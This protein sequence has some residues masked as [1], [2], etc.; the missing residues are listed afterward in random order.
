MTVAPVQLL[1]FFLHLAG[2]EPE[3]TWR[4]EGNGWGEDLPVLSQRELNRERLGIQFPFIKVNTPG[5]AG[6]PG[7]RDRMLAVE[8]RKNVTFLS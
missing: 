1:L 8:S 6:G 5:T 7:G 4:G 2:G 3:G